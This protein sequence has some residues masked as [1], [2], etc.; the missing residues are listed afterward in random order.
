MCLI[1]NQAEEWLRISIT[2]RAYGY[3]IDCYLRSLSTDQHASLRV[4]QATL[5]PS[6]GSAI[7]GD[8]TCSFRGTLRNFITF[9]GS[10][11][12]LSSTENCNS[13]CTD[14]IGH[15]SPIC[16]LPASLPAFCLPQEYSNQ[17]LNTCLRNF[18]FR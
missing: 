5:F 2:C 11:A 4:S 6:G 10:T 17:L 15:L 1:I 8:K 14:Q 7:I 16:S 9:T 13:S 12:V 18:S 3:S